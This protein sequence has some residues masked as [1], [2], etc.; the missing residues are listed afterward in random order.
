MSFSLFLLNIDCGTRQN[1][2]DEAVLTSINSICLRSQKEKIMYTPLNDIFPIS[3]RDFPGCSL[4]GLLDVLNEV[5]KRIT[6]SQAL[7]VR[8]ITL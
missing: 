2:R 1:Q 5:H 7:E 8:S 6:S 3:N 4:H